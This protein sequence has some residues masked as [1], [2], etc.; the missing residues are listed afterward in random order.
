MNDFS[1][2]DIA[3]IL[4]LVIKKSRHGAPIE[5]NYPAMVYSLIA[6]IVERIPTIKDL[7]KRLREDILFRLDCGFMLSEAALMNISLRLV[8]GNIH[9]AMIV[10]IQGMKRSNMF[11][12]RN[13]KVAH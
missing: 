7:V 2:V 4:R 3:P 11:D 6:R 9:I 10:M 12:Q 8:C 13:A 5:V 1:A